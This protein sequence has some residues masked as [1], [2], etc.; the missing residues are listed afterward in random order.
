[1]LGVSFQTPLSALSVAST[2]FRVT[3]HNV[4]N[5]NTDGFKESRVVLAEQP[6]PSS[7]QAAAPTGLHSG[8]HAS[9]IGLGVQIAAIQRNESQGV[10]VPTNHHPDGTTLDEPGF[11][12]LS[13]TD[14]SR[15]LVDLTTQSLLFR[16]NVAV[17][18]AGEEILDDLMNLTRR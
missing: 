7:G 14:L 12:E 3:S 13:N 16:T 2:T 10:L 5:L 8:E 17:I 11:K 15:N 4:A 18:N 6:P 1:M 9:Q